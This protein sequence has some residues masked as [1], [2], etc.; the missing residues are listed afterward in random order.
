M[1]VAYAPE[2]EI[3]KDEYIAEKIETKEGWNFPS[4]MI[5]GPEAFLKN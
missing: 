3:W 5:S 2:K 1:M 4:L